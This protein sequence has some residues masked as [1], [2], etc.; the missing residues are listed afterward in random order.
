MQCCT[1]CE[2]FKVTIGY[3]NHEVFSSTSLY[4]VVIVHVNEI[5]I[6]HMIN[7][8]K[9]TL[10]HQGTVSV[11]VG[12]ILRST[13]IYPSMFGFVQYLLPVWPLSHVRP[14]LAVVLYDV[15]RLQ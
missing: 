4:A 6:F 1:P 14:V 11:R 13:E 3:V 9:T 5:R 10:M 12:F 7:P 15:C 2:I 8:L